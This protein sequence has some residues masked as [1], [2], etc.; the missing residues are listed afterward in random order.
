M[1]PLACRLGLHAFTN[2]YNIVFYYLYFFNFQIF[3]K[4]SGTSVLLLILSAH[5]FWVENFWKKCDVSF[6]KALL[7]DV[8]FHW[9][10]VIIAFK[11]YKHWNCK[12]VIFFFSLL[13][14]YSYFFDSKTVY[15]IT[16]P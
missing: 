1:K 15:G 8:I 10:P 4:F 11:Y 13:L 12:S 9:I 6:A 14:I 2:W 5:I 7:I 3:K 16:L